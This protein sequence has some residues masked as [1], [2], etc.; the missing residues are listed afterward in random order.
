MGDLLEAVL[1][2]AV[3][4]KA[5]SI[6]LGWTA[7]R[8]TLELQA[9]GLQMRLAESSSCGRLSENSPMAWRLTG[10]YHT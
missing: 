9:R 7:S 5:N 1:K 3:I 10:H 6:E 4:L 2:I 8:T